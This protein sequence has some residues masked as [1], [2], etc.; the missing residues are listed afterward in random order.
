MW[1]IECDLAELVKICIRCFVSSTCSKMHLFVT[2]DRVFG[3]FGMELKQ[4]RVQLAKHLELI[5][6]S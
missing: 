5:W 3:N 2:S 6:K 1:N 4:V